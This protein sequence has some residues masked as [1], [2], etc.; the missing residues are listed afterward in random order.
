MQVVESDNEFIEK[1]QYQPIRQ[2]SYLYPSNSARQLR[3]L[4]P[5][6][7]K[8]YIYFGNE[9]ISH[10]CKKSNKNPK[11][12]IFTVTK[13]C[14]NSNVRSQSP[15]KSVDCYFISSQRKFSESKPI[16]FSECTYEERQHERQRMKKKNVK[17]MENEYIYYNK[18]TPDTRNIKSPTLDA[19]LDT[20]N[21]H[22]L[23]RKSA[24][25]PI[26]KYTKFSSFETL[27][28]LTKLDE[29]E[30]GKTDSSSLSGSY[31]LA[32]R[33]NVS[34]GIQ[35]SNRVA[36]TEDES[37][38]RP[39]SPFEFRSRRAK[40]EQNE[41]AKK[42]SD[43]NFINPKDSISKQ[44]QHSTVKVKN[45]D[46]K[47]A[48][49]SHG[50]YSHD[51]EV[52]SSNKYINKDKNNYIHKKMRE[53]K[54]INQADRAKR[55]AAKNMDIT[56]ER[57]RDQDGSSYQA[58]S[59]PRGE[60]LIMSI[61][62]DDSQQRSSSLDSKHTGIKRNSVAGMVQKY[63][64]TNS[65]Y[66]RSLYELKKARRDAR[67]K[68]NIGINN[69]DSSTR[70]TVDYYVGGSNQIEC[71]KSR[72]GLKMEQHDG[73][74]NDTS[75]KDPYTAKCKSIVINS[76]VD[77]KINNLPLT[78]S[79]SP[80]PG[81][82]GKRRFAKSDYGDTASE[83][84][85][86]QVPLITRMQSPSSFKENNYYLSSTVTS[87]RVNKQMFAANEKVI[88]EQCPNLKSEKHQMS[89]THPGSTRVDHNHSQCKD[90][91]TLTDNLLNKPTIQYA[92][93]TER[94][95]RFNRLTNEARQKCEA[96]HV[97]SDQ[98]L[99]NIF[100][101][102]L[103]DQHNQGSSSDLTRKREIVEQSKFI[104]DK[105]NASE[106]S[107][108]LQECSLNYATVSL[109]QNE[110]NINRKEIPCWTETTHTSSSHGP[111][112]KATQNK[113]IT[114][115][116]IN[117]PTQQQFSSLSSPFA[118]TYSKIPPS[119]RQDIQ[120]KDE[121]LPP[122]VP[123]SPSSYNQF[124]HPTS[125]SHEQIFKCQPVK[126]RLLFNHNK[127]PVSF[128][129]F[130]ETKWHKGDNREVSERIGRTVNANKSAPFDLGN[131]DRVFNT[132]S[133]ATINVVDH[134]LKNINKDDNY[135]KTSVSYLIPAINDNKIVI[136]P[137]QKSYRLTN[138]R[139]DAQ[140][141]KPRPYCQIRDVTA[142]SNALKFDK[143]A[144]KG[145]S[146]IEY[147]KHQYLKSLESD[148]I[149]PKRNLGEY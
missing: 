148:K 34:R 5:D 70:H 45:I 42:N 116:K 115:E 3:T 44:Y 57:L 23:E 13:P 43:A 94:A 124:I 109:A 123:P 39:D 149:F 119:H 73:R 21:Q 40:F 72:I 84:T 61:A 95:N 49:E 99:L 4:T 120:Q 131:S 113:Y 74:K 60:H 27:S 79:L 59:L 138:S 37:S 146:G 63:E 8:S 108:S 55:K 54:L 142:N 78:D 136:V 18:T 64:T 126:D 65:Q 97:N 1:N 22:A 103:I 117:V 106:K 67:R 125:Q 53:H 105:P 88:Q 81:E 6:E 134:R 114:A 83:V 132:K 130:I 28:N 100:F 98:R 50:R 58:N 25:R 46:S 15:S 41:W 140:T 2:F 62:V 69:E 7:I 82:V 33:C 80:R 76:S 68:T 85:Q 122:P 104:R 66:Y 19:F 102:R 110:G 107:M 29:I 127:S 118:L 24:K 9:R 121:S 90:T 11:R 89:T 91:R 52:Y 92:T 14:E 32:K 16:M 71:S 48:A 96:Y 56:V 133:I 93:A 101:E 112:F 139:I 75:T 20:Y 144:S 47:P 35:S 135:Q 128:N 145:M 111:Y 129:D 26:E 30:Q 137:L 10:I 38:S 147:R 17:N 141:T 36:L 87:S 31:N 51:V 86:N 12:K 77:Q 143:D